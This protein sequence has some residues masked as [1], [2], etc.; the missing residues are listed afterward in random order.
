MG[1]TRFDYRVIGESRLS[2][3]N[4]VNV[5]KQLNA[6]DNFVRQEMALAA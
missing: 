2:R 3:G 4:W 1:V 6:N 5:T